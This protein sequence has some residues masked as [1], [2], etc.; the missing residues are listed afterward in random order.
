MLRFSKICDVKAKLFDTPEIFEA[1]TLSLVK[2]TDRQYYEVVIARRESFYILRSANGT[3]IAVL[4]KHTTR[5][6]QDVQDQTSIRYE[7]FIETNEWTEGIRV[8]NQTGKPCILALNVV[9][10]GSR[11][12]LSTIGTIFSKA[13]LYF[14]HPIRCP[15]GI[16]YNNPHYLSFSEITGSSVDTLAASSSTQ[17]VPMQPQYS[18]LSCLEDLHQHGSLRSIQVNSSIQ[19]ELL[20]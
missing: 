9:V 12:D 8:W 10:Y 6:L 17:A 5:C 15:P 14:Q 16:E 3:D 18:I 11:P 19:T 7:S 1:C 13:R 2:E 4:N 20:V